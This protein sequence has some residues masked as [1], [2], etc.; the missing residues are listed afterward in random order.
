MD[1]YLIAKRTLKCGK[2]CGDDGITPEFL[3]Y[4]GLDETI[5]GFINKSYTTKELPQEWRT[6]IIV[7]V[8]KTGDLSKPD[9]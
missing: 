6:L 4:V 5:L 1:E 9:N 8:Q 3:K 7:P 2:S